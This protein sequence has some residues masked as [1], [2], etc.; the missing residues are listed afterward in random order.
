MT[1][2]PD[3]FAQ[4]IELLRKGDAEAIE[5]FVNEYGAYLRRSL[6]FRI[7]RSALQSAADSVDICQSVLGGFLLRL[8]AGGYEIKSKEDLHRLLTAIAN[9]KFLMFQRREFAQKRS[10]KSTL[11]INRMAEPHEPN[12][13]NGAQAME[14]TEIWDKASMLMSSE[15]QELLQ[16]RKAG[17][18]W[19]EIAVDRNVS[20]LLLRKRLS[21]ALRRVA[22]ELG[23]DY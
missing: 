7:R 23:L 5:S 6:R 10:R 13:D 18:S 16:R 3:N 21:R 22:E 15:E 9:K 8:S 12:A 1:T 14:L 20:P 11:S 19:E 2:E 4:I 17:H